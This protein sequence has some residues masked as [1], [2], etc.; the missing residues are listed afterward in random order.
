MS[1]EVGQT[2]LCSRF[3]VN[4]DSRLLA[5]LVT[6]LPLHR[7]TGDEEVTGDRQCWAWRVKVCSLPHDPAAYFRRPR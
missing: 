2:L 4:P 1:P 3:K 6:R 7:N 5:Q